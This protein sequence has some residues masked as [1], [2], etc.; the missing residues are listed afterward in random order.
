MELRLL[1]HNFAFKK[2]N[3]EKKYQ[4]SF[5]PRTKYMWTWATAE[6]ID[7]S[8][9]DIDIHSSGM[10]RIIFWYVLAVNQSKKL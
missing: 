2:W 3:N 5:G 10:L 6:R 1:R 7:K 9:L 8:K 4:N